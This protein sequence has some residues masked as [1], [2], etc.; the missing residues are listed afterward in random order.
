MEDLHAKFMK[1]AADLETA[2]TSLQIMA[3]QQQ[4][5]WNEVQFWQQQAGEFH[6][7]VKF[8]EKE[9]EDRDKGDYNQDQ[10]DDDSFEEASLE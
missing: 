3:V 4:E 1:L 10:R 2:T 8:L 7:R 9:L 5:L 6:A